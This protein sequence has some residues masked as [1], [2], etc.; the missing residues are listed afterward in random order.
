MQEIRP[1]FACIYAPKPS[2]LLVECANVFSP[3]VERTA[4]DTIVFDLDGLERLFGSYSEIG[5]KVAEQAYRS[6]GFKANVAVASNPDAAICAAR[7]FT[8]ITIV[9]RGTEAQRLSSLAVDVLSP[10]P[11][12]LETLNRWGIHT[13][14]EFAKLPAVQISERLGQEGVRLHKLAPGS[15]S[16]PLEP[17][18]ETLRFEDVVE[19]DYE[20]GTIEPLTFILS[21]MLDHLCSE[22]RKRNLATPEVRL[23]L[24]SFSRVLHLPIPVR[25]PRL[26]TKL[27]I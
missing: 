20:I 5:A 12:I 4:A 11:E 1:V 21:R 26:L 15:A 22:L 6:L 7:G 23:T 19:L 9:S 13:L 27:L 16:R 2:D 18:R 14:G 25:N 3:R 8:G 10:A 17:H 24:G